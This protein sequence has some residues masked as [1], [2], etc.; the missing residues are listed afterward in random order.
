MPNETEV[1][2]TLTDTSASATT[3]VD[4]PA[5]EVFD[6]VRAPVNHPSI[7]GDGTVRGVV[8]GPDLLQAESTFRMRMRRGVPY[9]ITSRVV[10]FE[11][12]RV[13]A[14]HHRGG[15]RWRWQLE[16]LDGAR[17][18]VTETYDQSRT[19][20]APLLRL[21]GYPKN[22]MDNVASSVARVAEHF[23]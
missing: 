7:S 11:R 15:N 1:T 2:A 16:P 10:E 3:V 5:G 8:R 23:S 9:R 22:H 18:R 6:F 20:L 19:R 14:W 12:D 17:T 4:A 21:L 13:I